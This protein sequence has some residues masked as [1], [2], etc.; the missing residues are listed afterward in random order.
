MSKY[1]G[2]AQL[3]VRTT[4]LLALAMALVV[5]VGVGGRAMS[6]EAVDVA[7]VESVS[8]QGAVESSVADGDVKLKAWP[9]VVAVVAVA[10]I[11]WG[12]RVIAVG[13][14]FYRAWLTHKTAI[15]KE[16]KR[17]GQGWAANSI[18]RGAW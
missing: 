11:T 10:I 4:K 6:Q 16:L 18:C 9:A 14:M 7:A 12:P 17:L 3:V 2:T 8:L 1:A 5:V 15:C 13:G